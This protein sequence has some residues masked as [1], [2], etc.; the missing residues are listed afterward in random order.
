M[1]HFFSKC[2]VFKTQIVINT[3]TRLIFEPLSTTPPPPITTP[4]QHI[5]NPGTYNDVMPIQSIVKYR[6]K[7][8]YIIIIYIVKQTINM[9]MLSYFVLNVIFLK[10]ISAFS[11]IKLWRYEHMSILG[12]PGIG[13]FSRLMRNLKS[14]E[15]FEYFALSLEA[16]VCT[17]GDHGNSSTFTLF[18]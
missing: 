9:Y 17:P 18:I 10:P 6:R 14:L 11:Y 7:Y 15:W 8:T 4:A 3:K 5:L 16:G 12:K 2:G 1:I 13:D